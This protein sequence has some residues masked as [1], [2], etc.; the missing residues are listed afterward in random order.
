MP[1]IDRSTFRD[2]CQ[3][4]HNSPEDL[5]PDLN[6]SHFTM[7]DGAPYEH[8]ARQAFEFIRRNSNG[9]Y[10]SRTLMRIAHS[11]DYAEMAR[12]GLQNTAIT[13][14]TA[15]IYILEMP[16]SYDPDT[17]V[18]SGGIVAACAYWPEV[19]GRYVL[20]VGGNSRRQ[21]FGSV[22]TKYIQYITGNPMYVWVSP[23]NQTGQHF[24]LTMGFAAD[25]INRMGT[26]R[27]AH[28]M[29]DLEG[30]DPSGGRDVEVMLVATARDRRRARRASRNSPTSSYG[31][32]SP[33]RYEDDV[34]AAPS[35]E[36]H[37]EESDPFP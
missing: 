24:L 1:T 4:W 3:D 37:T 28:G 18:K 17:E 2:V 22:L 25:T 27:W 12:M 29:N 33:T 30:D 31:G 21:R 9:R 8:G 34:V 16:S 32:V 35:V 13:V 5:V 20:A 6:L 7:S 10:S 23:E 14:P 15:D 36:W 19:D 26:L 11:A